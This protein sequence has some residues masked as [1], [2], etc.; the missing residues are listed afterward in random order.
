[1][2]SNSHGARPVDSNLD[3]FVDFDQRVVDKELSLSG[4]WGL[5]ARAEG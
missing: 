2:N 4:I 5:S 1:M 3:D